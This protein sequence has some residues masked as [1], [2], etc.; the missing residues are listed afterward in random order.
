MS[1]P[2]TSKTIEITVDPAGS[3]SVKT[4][5]F[6]GSSCKDASRFIEQALGQAGTEKLLPEYF[7]QAGVSDRI[8]QGN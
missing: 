7:Q 1:T 6:T 2:H 4:N 8:R 3:V 5:G